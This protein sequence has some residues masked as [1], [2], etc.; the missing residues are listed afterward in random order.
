MHARAAVLVL[1]AGTAASLA[2]PI[3]W[4]DPVSGDWNV[5]ANW[6]PANVPNTAGEDAVI[7]VGG[8]Y[9][10]STGAFS[11]SIGSLLITNP[12]AVLN[13]LN[14]RSVT[15]NA[16]ASTNDG[17]IRINP[18]GAGGTA[19][20][21]VTTDV[22]LSGV[23]EIHLL[24]GA[25]TSIGGLGSL[26]NAAGHA[27]RGVG[28][29]STTITNDGVIAADSS[30]A[31]SGGTLTISVSTITNNAD[32]RS[33]SGTLAISG[34]GIDQTGGGILHVGGTVATTNSTIFGGTLLHAGG[35]F[36]ADAGTTTLDAVTSD[37]LIEVDPT[38]TLAITG[39]LTNDG[40]ITVNSTNNGSNAFVRFDE[41]A[42][43][44]GTG[45]ISLVGAA[46]NAQL[47]TAVGVTLTQSAGHKIDGRGQINATLINDG[48]IEADVAGDTLLLQVGPK[49]NNNL[50]RA[51][52][53]GVLRIS[54]ITITQGAAGELVADSGIVEL[55]SA[56]IEGGQ[57]NATGTGEVRT[58]A[59]TSVL[60][61]V[62]LGGP[63]LVNPNHTLAIQGGLTNNDIVSI[64]PTNNGSN[65]FVRFDETCTV[66]GVGSIDLVGSSDNSQ[67]TSLAGAT[68]TNAAGHTI[69][70]IGQVHAL[71]HNEGIVRADASVGVGGD[72]LYLQA[73][74]KTNA[75]DMVAGPASA[76]RITG[77][78]I[79]QT[80]GGR[81][82]AEDGAIELSSASV[83]GGS[84]EASGA[85]TAETFAGTVTLDAV[86]NVAPFNVNTAHTL[87]FINGLTN[88]GIIAVNPTNNGVNAT[89]RAGN[90]STI[91]GVGEI[92]LVGS[93]ENSILTS[94]GGVL[95]TNGPTHTIRGV[96]YINGSLHN[97]GFVRGDASVGI[98][99]G[100]LTLLTVNKSNAGLI[101]AEPAS[102]VR[103]SG[104]AL[105]QS[106]GGTL[107]AD[108]GQIELVSA[109]IIG[110]AIDAV[111]AGSVE[112]VS[113]TSTLNGL[114]LDAPANVN[115]AHVIV[116]AN[117]VVNN[118]D[119]TVNP[120][121]NGT[122]A[123]L[124]MNAGSTIT[125][126][127][128]IVLRGALDNSQVVDGPFTQG[129]SH[130]LA[131]IGN[132]AAPMTNAG[133]VAPGLS[134]G[135]MQVT[136][137]GS[138]T[139]TSTS[140]FDFELAGPASHDKLI[141]NGAY[142]LAGTLRL[143]IADGWTPARGEVM[144]IIDGASVTGEFDA[145]DAPSLGAKRLVVGYLPD[146]VRVVVTCSAD[147]TGSADP[148][149][150]E[151]GVP[152]GIIDANDFF[153]YLDQFASGNLEEADLTGSGDPNDPQY[154]VP[155]G[156]ID[157]NDFFYY[158]DIFVNG[159]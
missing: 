130:T 153:Y 96:G 60:R 90:D 138:I 68:V 9:T 63:V 38:A 120:T 20:L 18:V 111:G 145:V 149:D 155:D 116:I 105:D 40:L 150:P 30:I 14:S 125:G 16:A 27:I 6:D 46:D 43:L 92:H 19:S 133:T 8:T 59:G 123:L 136:S 67:V 109:T 13:I 157:G 118:G 55:S 45:K 41:T 74:N 62:T 107:R 85:G 32:L 113:G 1:I 51:V 5:P 147:L 110:G 154:G 76:L 84:I 151:Y 58:V 79:D 17:L 117:T 61:A 112:T 31:V 141:G 82:L 24:T 143:S 29:L 28:T 48:I 137:A 129:S 73:A 128:A 131:G 69:R 3:E 34:S 139:C 98:A 83:V 87:S 11:P 86:T 94:L 127:G 122:N 81:L 134:I 47:N 115:S 126:S 72:T 10:V 50:M 53:D 89:M 158:L 108:D 124:R 78:A 49:S 56:T 97:L 23:G 140:L 159:C 7:S 22:T 99:G 142:T 152:D 146:Q 106:S 26:T 21:L 148:N 39:G 135:T 44:G 132:L 54:G 101:A 104:I 100:T 77:I 66:G 88:N 114:T 15:L 33:D 70:G 65:A 4:A 35:Q 91:D 156:V 42:A 36:L 102:K 103:I 37:A 119:L 144:T 93:L 57:V 52:G 12:D 71:L 64:N 95:L 80:P 121:N 75:A 2:Q 25:S